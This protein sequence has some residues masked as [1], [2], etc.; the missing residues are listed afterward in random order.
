MI[1]FADGCWRLVSRTVARALSLV[2]RLRDVIAD[3]CEN[4]RKL[5]A[6]LF[7]D[8]YRL[9]SKTTTIF[10]SCAEAFPSPNKGDVSWTNLP[11]RVARDPRCS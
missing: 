5:E 1:A 10:R 4:R 9:V 7:H 8:R 3:V 11:R 6:E 2:S